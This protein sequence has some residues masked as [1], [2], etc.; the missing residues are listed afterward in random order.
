MMKELRRSIGSAGMTSCDAGMVTIGSAPFGARSGD[1]RL[2][3]ARDPTTLPAFDP[4]FEF[5][6]D[7]VFEFA[8]DA[9]RVDDAVE[10]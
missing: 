6:L 10:Q 3:L 4:G 5:A 2:L 9:A 1:T 8:R 7:A